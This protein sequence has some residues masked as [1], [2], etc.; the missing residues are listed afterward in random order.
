MSGDD[1]SELG[2]S[3]MFEIVDSGTYDPPE[4]A[5]AII[6]HCDP[7]VKES[8]PNVCIKADRTTPGDI[9][10]PFSYFHQCQT[11]HHCMAR[12]KD[13]TLGC[14]FFIFVSMD[15]IKYGKVHSGIKVYIGTESIP[16]K[17]LVAKATY[18]EAK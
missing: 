18:Q 15:N 3:H 7:T 16:F 17:Y 1:L 11:H 14:Y 2:L 6:F 12:P 10:R 13:K 4:N 9:I 5:H 8:N